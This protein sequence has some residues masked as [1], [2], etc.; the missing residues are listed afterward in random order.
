M[1]V[2]VNSVKSVESWN[3]GVH[4]GTGFGSG[5]SNGSCHIGG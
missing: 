3:G 2:L 1:G 5:I 4:V